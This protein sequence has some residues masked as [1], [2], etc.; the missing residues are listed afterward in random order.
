KEKL[1]NKHSINEEV[2][3]HS[4]EASKVNYEYL[5]KINSEISSF[6]KIQLTEFIMTDN[7]IFSSDR[8]VVDC[9]IQSLRNYVISFK[10]I[11]LIC[12]DDYISKRTSI[13]EN[14]VYLLSSSKFEKFYSGNLSYEDFVDK[15]G[16][17]VDEY[18]K[19]LNAS[20]SRFTRLVKSMIKSFEDELNLS[21]SLLKEHFHESEVIH[22]V[23]FNKFT[24]FLDDEFKNKDL[25]LKNVYDSNN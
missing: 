17:I 2:I 8:K 15:F 16:V 25:I 7:F 10:E 18:L 11:L 12:A 19:A 9:L 21:L 14:L 13:I 22:N 6:D 4:N 23:F 3:L 5:E 24:K 1:S 20:F